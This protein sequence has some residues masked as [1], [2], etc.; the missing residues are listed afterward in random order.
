MRVCRTKT[1]E[2]RIMLVSIQFPNW[3]RSEQKIQLPMSVKDKIRWGNM[4][5]CVDWMEDG[6]DFLKG[7]HVLNFSLKP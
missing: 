2:P 5:P 6:Y 3:Y 1:D 4:V 7:A